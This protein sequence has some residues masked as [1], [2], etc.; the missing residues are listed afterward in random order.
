MESAVL[1]S[2]QPDI[3]AALNKLSTEGTTFWSSIPPD[4]FVD[5][6]EQGWS[7]AQNVLHLI[8]SVKPVAKALKLPRF[9]LRM[10]FGKAKAPSRHYAALRSHYLE[11]IQNYELKGKYAPEAVRVTETS[12]LTQKKLV[13]SLTKALESLSHAVEA[14]QEQALDQYQLPHPLIGKLTVR[15]MLFFTLFHYEHHAEN[16]RAKLK[17]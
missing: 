7:P 17:R 13:A 14:W 1:P 3:L 10:L 5:Q 16:V 12:A 4:V 8:K 6:P 15:E 2:S 11:R 9:L